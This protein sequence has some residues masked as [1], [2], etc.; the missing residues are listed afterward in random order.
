MSKNKDYFASEQEVK[1]RHINY[2]M[3]NVWNHDRGK[4][5][6]SNVDYLET[7]DICGLEGISLQYYE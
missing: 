4:Q 5:Y 3:K 6:Q 2:I 1:Q 7:L